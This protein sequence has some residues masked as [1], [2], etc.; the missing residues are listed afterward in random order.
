VLIPWTSSLVAAA[1]PAVD[2]ADDGTWTGVIAL[3]N[4]WSADNR[5]LTLDDD[6]PVD[7]RPLPLPVT[8]QYITGPGHDGATVGLMTLD[9]AWRDGP[10][11]MGRGRIDM[12]DPQGAALARKIRGGFLRFVSADIDKVDGHVV[13]I[14]DSGQALEDC[15][16]GEDGT[17]TGELYTQWRIMGASL[18]AHPAFPEAQIELATDQQQDEATGGGPTVGYDPAWGCVRPDGGGKWEPADC[19]A[20][21]AVPAGPNKDRPHDPEHT[22]PPMPVTAAATVPTPPSDAPNS[23]GPKSEG[24]DLPNHLPTTPGTDGSEPERDEALKQA[25]A[26]AFDDPGAAAVTAAVHIDGWLPPTDWFRSPD[27]T[28]LQPITVD[29]DGRVR[30]YLATWGVT[31]RSFPGRSVTPPRSPSGYG[32]FNTRPVHT[33]EGLVDVGLI[34]MGIGHAALGLDL[35]AAVA[36]Y[37]DTGTMAA[38]VRAGED[39]RGIWLA[40]AVLP[41]LTSEQR[42]RLS[43]SRFSGDWRQEGGGLELVAALAVPTEGFPVPV[44]RRGDRGDYALVAAGALPAPSTCLSLNLEDEQVDG[45]RKEQLARRASMAASRMRFLRT[46]TTARRISAFAIWAAKKTTS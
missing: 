2:V 33:S 31:H 35:R 36:H 38:V 12:D 26:E 4:Q 20:D 27:L 11:L 19:D 10:R 44:K 43:L 14:D 45:E 13:C 17:Q 28:E 8:V 41:D 39:S 1:A 37:D 22:R 23:T 29:D 21:N 34:T 32:L 42:L 15:T 16:P 9:E 24:L 18:L 7:V 30:G 5:M 25:A 3:I 46:Q 40:G 6:A